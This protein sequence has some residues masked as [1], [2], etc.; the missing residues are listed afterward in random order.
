MNLSLT[1]SR[2][3]RIIII[4]IIKIIYFTNN[5]KIKGKE[6]I[7]EISDI[8]G[9]ISSDLTLEEALY[10]IAVKWDHLIIIGLMGNTSIMYGGLG[11]K[12]ANIFRE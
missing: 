6:V 7:C 4:I 10:F 3:Q 9:Y 1:R 2:F 11:T 8:I 12:A 5:K